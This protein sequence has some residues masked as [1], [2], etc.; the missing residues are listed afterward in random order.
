MEKGWC[1]LTD[2]DIDEIK[3]TMDIYERIG[4]YIYA[5]IYK[6]NFRDRTQAWE[7]A[8]KKYA[9][10][11]KVEYL[12]NRDPRISAAGVLYRVAV[13]LGAPVYKKDLASLFNINEKS[14]RNGY[15]DFGKS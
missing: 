7:V 11:K 12:T 5:G 2:K 1:A 13:I 15:R 6:L 9:N 10:L 14:V 4:K 8:R 3:K